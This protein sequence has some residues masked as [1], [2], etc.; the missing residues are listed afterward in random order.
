MGFSMAAS[1]DIN[2]IFRE[3]NRFTGDG[4]PNPPTNAPLPVGD[5]QS[6]VYHPKK[7]ELR[8]VFGGLAT[9][10]EEGIA[11]VEGAI[12]AIEAAKNEALAEVAASTEE[13]EAA[14]ELAIQAADQAA[15]VGAGDVPTYPSRALAMASNIPAART[16]IMTAG[17]EA[18]GDGG[19]ALY[20]RTPAPSPAEAWHFQSADGAWWELSEA[21][22]NV[23]MFGAKGDNSANDSAATQAALDFIFARGGTLHFTAG[24]YR[25]YQKIF[26]DLRGVTGEPNTNTRRV[27]IK[28]DGKGNTIIKASTDAMNTFHIQGD[29]PLTSASHAHITISDLGFAGGTPTPRTATGLFL[30]DVAFLTVAECTFTNLHVGLL[31]QG[32][33]SSNFTGLT[34]TSNNKGTQTQKGDSAPNA[35]LYLGCEWRQNLTMAFD[36][37]D[38]TSGVSFIKCQIEG[39]GTQGNNSTGGVLLRMD[40]STGEA[41]PTFM[42]CY[43]ETNRGGFDVSLSNAGAGRVAAT[44]IGNNFNRISTTSFVT[45]NIRTAGAIDLNLMGNTFSR[46]GT[47]V[48]DAGRKYLNLS[49]QTKLR[50]VGNRWKDAVEAPIIGQGLPYQGFVRG[51]LGASVTGTLP[52]GW[53]VS[54]VA[55]GVFQITH[56]L[57]HTDYAFVAMVAAGSDR[58]AY[59]YVASS[60]SLQV[61]MGTVGSTATREDLDFS[62]FLSELKP[63]S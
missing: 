54:Q 37:Y 56:N 61:T 39:N 63:A 25:V 40:G 9:E 51:S 44:F 43:I 58:A 41:G 24:T 42:Q 11:T 59:R 2:R 12:P 49:A 17:Y 45:N 34:F 32:C 52:N 29:N 10:L 36:G 1:D 20:K 16:Y 19:R 26:L 48:A 31:N 14:A 22:P 33:L 3:F 46:L 4:L 28:G 23:K 50:D 7:A 15:V 6:G 27:N 47:Y 62:F 57:G 5:P 8:G 53:S 18:A 13:A 21:S 60:N 38:N 30:Q 55:T 35:N